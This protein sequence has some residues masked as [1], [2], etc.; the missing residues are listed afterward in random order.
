[1]GLPRGG[2]VLSAATLGASAG[3]P[4]PAGAVTL[5]LKPVKGA[6]QPTPVSGQ[7]VTVSAS[8]SR[9]SLPI[10]VTAQVLWR[11]RW[12]VIGRGTI[13]PDAPLNVRFR[14]GGAN[15]LRLVYGR[16]TTRPITVSVTPALY[17]RIPMPF[18][19]RHVVATDAAVWVMGASER[20]GGVDR[21]MA[22]DPASGKPLH[23]AVD[24]DQAFYS[25]LVRAGADAYVRVGYDQARR[26][27]PATGGPA[28]PLLTVLTSGDCAVARCVARIVTDAGEVAIDGDTDPL[29]G[30]DG[31]TWAMGGTLLEGG[32]FNGRL[33]RLPTGGGTAVDRGPVGVI[34][35]HGG[36]VS[37]MAA[38]NGGVWLRNA[39]GVLWWAASAGT[40][41]AAKVP[42]SSVEALATGPT[43][44][45]AFTQDGT[46]DL[47]ELKPAGRMRHITL[48]RVDADTTNVAD[49]S[50]DVDA[51]AA[52]IVES[53]GWTLVRVPVS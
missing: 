4:A 26:L 19:A 13:G 9:N 18:G 40:A 6:R 53:Y 14:R 25:R 50:F 12:R 8:F 48:G 31:F 36:G 10:A 51:K 3:V 2:A 5:K 33:V 44:A 15:R 49:N 17:P 28:G 43:G 24:V 38:V 32:N 22:L 45:W 21:V 16:R 34:S 42:L 52:W 46:S 37:V 47:V 35:Q 23:P 1:M 20:L 30:P 11:G 27:D 29:K 39:D 41:P 7:L